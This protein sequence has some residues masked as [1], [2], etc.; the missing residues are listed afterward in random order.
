V[1]LLPSALLGRLSAAQL[2]A[3]LAHEREH[4][5][6]HDN[7]IAHVHHLVQALFWFHPLVW[8]IGR[9][10]LE[11]RESAC[12]EAVLDHGHDAR[13]YAEGILAVCSHC[14][15]LHH[16][17]GTASALSG[18]LTER[19]RAIIRHVP[20]VSL[21]F[22][23]AFALSACTL[24]LGIAPLLAGAT[25]D[26][27]R[28]YE[29]LVNDSRILWTA[30]VYITPAAEGGRVHGLH[31][32]ADRRAV[33]VRNAT[34]RELV[35]LSYGVPLTHINGGPW[36]DVT[37]YDFRAELHEPVIDPERFDPS[38]LR[39]AV[40]KLLASRFDLQVHVN[41]QCQAPCGKYRP[42]NPSL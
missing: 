39:G 34:L 1:V 15:D 30:A 7:L 23:K 42:G 26:G 31:V 25:D 19:I 37:H 17:G 2:D 29:Q 16:A 10:M 20:P 14:H 32:Q 21:G 18:N 38:A 36:L 24:A 27:A 12:D 6:R 4:I 13:Q 33:M 28:R 40:N 22:C 35:A 11:E 9:Q 3:V 8:W 41:Q 5:A